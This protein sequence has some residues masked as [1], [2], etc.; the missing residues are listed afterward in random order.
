MWEFCEHH[1]RTSNVERRGV[2]AVHHHQNA[3]GL[4]DGGSVL[5]DFGDRFGNCRLVFFDRTSEST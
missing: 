5:G 4:F 1:F 3:F 2:D